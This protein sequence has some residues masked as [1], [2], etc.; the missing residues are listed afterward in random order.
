MRRHYSSYIL[1]PDA[2]LAFVY[3]RCLR[4]CVCVSVSV[5][6]CVKHLFV[7][8]ITR[9]L[10]KLGSPNLDQRYKTIWLSALLFS[11]V[12]NIDLQGQI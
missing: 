9:G 3:C 2:S 11:G 5:S 6:L 4:L 1:L 7:R 12:I 8:A 10:L